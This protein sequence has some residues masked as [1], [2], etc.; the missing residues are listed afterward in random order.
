[1]QIA[2]NTLEDHQS[3]PRCDFDKLME[4]SAKNMELMKS[5]YGRISVRS[6]TMTKS[7]TECDDRAEP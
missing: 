2:V 7:C 5:V 4:L 3:L 1:M 6:A